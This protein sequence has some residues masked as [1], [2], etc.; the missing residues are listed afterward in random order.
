MV[1]TLL[2]RQRLTSEQV[3][4]ARQH[5]EPERRRVGTLPKGAEESRGGLAGPAR[6][7]A[8][9]PGRGGRASPTRTRSLTREVVDRTCSPCDGSGVGIGG[10]CEAV[11]HV[12]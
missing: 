11:V 1:L 2:W 8:G 9:R 7:R 10:N 6:S 3:T 12:H 5:Q 4:A